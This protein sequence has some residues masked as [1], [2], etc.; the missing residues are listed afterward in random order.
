MEVQRRK[1]REVKRIRKGL[2]EDLAFVMGMR[3]WDMEV[4]WISGKNYATSESSE[5]NVKIIILL[6]HLFTKSFCLQFYLR[7]RFDLYT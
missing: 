5:E 7:L 4:G 2:E 6:S 1:L 3:G